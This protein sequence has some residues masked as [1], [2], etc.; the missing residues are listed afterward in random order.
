MGWPCLNKWSVCDK[1]MSSWNVKKKSSWKLHISQSKWVIVLSSKLID[2]HRES[3]RQCSTV[4]HS[5]V[6][7]GHWVVG[8]SIYRCLVRVPTLTSEKCCVRGQGM[9]IHGWHPHLY[10]TILISATR[11]TLTEKHR[12]LV[13][14]IHAKLSER[15][16]SRPSQPWTKHSKYQQCYSTKS[17]MTWVKMILR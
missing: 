7:L 17:Q 16:M 1:K 10:N 2:T 8:D 11:G 3:L 14:R 12:T 9:R 4:T 5:Q 13:H 6:L 15:F